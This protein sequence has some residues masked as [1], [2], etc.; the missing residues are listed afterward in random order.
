MLRRAG[1]CAGLIALCAAVPADAAACLAPGTEVVLRSNV[2]DPD[3]FV[4]DSR[5]R[6]IDYVEGPGK[7]TDAV[8]HHTRLSRPGTRALVIACATAVA[9]A[10]EPDRLENVVGVKILNGPHR[11]HYGWVISEDVHAG[12]S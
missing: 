4:W 2:Y 3:V 5:Q 10:H 6:V 11:G 9:R 7:T 1:I 8:L 12:G